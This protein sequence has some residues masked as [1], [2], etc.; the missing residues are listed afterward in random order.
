MIEGCFDSPN[1]SAPSRNT[2][3]ATYWFA[4]LIRLTTAMTDATPITTP[5]SVR[6]LRSLCAQRLDVAIA[7]ASVKCMDEVRGIGEGTKI[8]RGGEVN[9]STS[10]SVTQ[11]RHGTMD[12][13]DLIAFRELS[14]RHQ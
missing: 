12:Q 8:I 14:G 6:M 4:P 5:I 9:V 2:R 11:S 13:I 1:T 7:T 10:T 3:V